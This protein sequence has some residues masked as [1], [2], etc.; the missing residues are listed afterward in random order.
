[1]NRID[2]KT[3]NGIYMF[4]TVSGNRYILKITDEKI[5]LK[6]SPKN[7]KFSLR[8]DNKEIKVFKFMPIEV[9][10]GAILK[11]EPLGVGDSTWRF[12]TKVIDIWEGNDNKQ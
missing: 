9:G 2:L 6:R 4:C 7:E 10:K 12:T 1:M 8:K 5:T 11:M 3:R